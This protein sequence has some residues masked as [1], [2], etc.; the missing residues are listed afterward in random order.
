MILGYLSTIS[1]WKQWMKAGM[2]AIDETTPFNKHT[3]YNRCRIDSPNGP[4]TLTIPVQKY[5]G[6][7]CKIG[8]VMIS[9]HG[10]WRHKHWHALS[11]TYFNSPYFEYYQDD[12]HPIYF[13]NQQRLVDFNIQLNS[14]IVELLGL[15]SL[16]SPILSARWGEKTSHRG[17]TSE[18]NYYQV[19]AHK[20]G[21]IPN[22]S[23][24]DLLFNMGPE[25]ILTL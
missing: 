12:F 13:G 7:S 18:T 9:E 10:D 16:K 20:H 14:L 25:A 1:E 24:I 15:S 19:F 5:E 22:L 8:D 17:N 2:P 4:L 23:I 6:K 11:Y 3:D 21:F